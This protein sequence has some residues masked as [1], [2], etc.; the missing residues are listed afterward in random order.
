MMKSYLSDLW[1]FAKWFC[2]VLA[3]SVKK[4]VNKMDYPKFWQNIFFWLTISSAIVGIDKLF[5]ASSVLFG[6]FFV[7]KHWS[8]GEWKRWQREQKKYKL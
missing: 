1:W 6:I 4:S 3:E 7:V 2:H 8:T 5:Y